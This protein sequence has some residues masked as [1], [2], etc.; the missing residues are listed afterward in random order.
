[1]C[2]PGPRKTKYLVSGST[3][4][5]LLWRH[6]VLAAWCVLGSV[7]SVFIC[8][9]LKILINQQRPSTARQRD[10]GMPSSH[11][12]NLAFL[13]TYTAASLLQST[14]APEQM[15]GGAALVVCGALFLTWLRVACGYHTVPQVAVGYCTGLATAVWWQHT[16]VSIMFPYLVQ[17]PGLNMYLAAATSIAMLVFVY[18]SK[19][20]QSV[21]AGV[22]D[23][24]A[25]AKRT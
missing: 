8:K 3:L 15:Y 21:A 12:N 1:M 19:M 13:S 10:P 2:A 16:G 22:G 11:A 24:V 20:V 4:A 7:I 25:K 18:Q 23:L 17:N 9:L 6:D 14:A 5:V